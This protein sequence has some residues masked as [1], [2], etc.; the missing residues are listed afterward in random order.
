MKTTHFQRL[1][2][3][4]LVVCMVWS[5]APAFTLP[6]KAATTDP[7]IVIAGSDFQGTTSTNLGAD[8]VSAILTQITGA[9]YTSADGFL[10]AGDYDYYSM[11]NATTV[12]NNKATLKGLID[13][14]Y[15][16]MEDANQ[17]YIQGNHDPDSTVD[18]TNLTVTGAHDH[19]KGAYG[20]YV[21][22]QDVLRWH[23]Y[24]T[25][26]EA[27]TGAA[28]LRGYLNEKLATGFSKP[29]FIVGH[30]PLHYTMRTA[31]AGDGR[32]AH[33]FFDAMND[34]AAAGLNIIYLFGHHH[35][36]SWLDSQGGSAVYYGKGDTIYIPQGNRTDY[37]EET[38]NFT[39]MNAGFVGYYS[40]PNTT[41]GVEADLT[42]S[43]FE[44]TGD[45][46]KIYRYSADGLHDVKSRG[47]ANTAHTEFWSPLTNVISSPV[48]VTLNDI[49]ASTDGIT[50]VSD[51][52]TG[53]TATAIVGNTPYGYTA[54][55]T[56]NIKVTGYTKGNPATVTI[57]V[58]ATFDASRPAIVIDHDIG[59]VHTCPIVDGKVTFTTYH[60]SDYTVAQ[61]GGN[62]VSNSVTLPKA[63]KQINSASELK[64][65]VPYIISDYQM[66]W[67]LTN[68]A[69]ITTKNSYPGLLLDG[70]PSVDT[71]H[72]WYLTE[73]GY[74]VYGSATSTDYLLLGTGEKPNRTLTV[75]A[76]TE[77]NAGLAATIVDY[78][79]ANL[80]IKN[81]EGTGFMNRYGGGSTDNVAT[82][83][84]GTD[85][86]SGNSYWHVYE[87]VKPVAQ[88]SAVAS[89]AALST[90]QTAYVIPTVTVD[91]V[92]AEDVTLTYTSSDPSVATV[93]DDGLI[94][95]I[96]A[97]NVWIKVTLTAVNGET[98]A[99]PISVDVPIAVYSVDRD[100][101]YLYTYG[102]TEKSGI[103][104]SD[105]STGGPYIIENKSP[106]AYLTGNG[107]VTSAAGATG[108]E[109]VFTPDYD[110]VWYYVDGYLRYGK[111]T[112]PYLAVVDGKVAL[113]DDETQA[114][115][116]VY[117]HDPDNTTYENCFIIQNTNVSGRNA[118]NQFGGLTN[119]A[120]GLYVVHGTSTWKFY[121]VYDAKQIRF[122]L[123]NYPS[124]LKVGDEVELSPAVTAGT[125]KSNT[126]EITWGSSDTSVA[127]VSADGVITA[128]KN[129][130]TTITGTITAVGGVPMREDISLSF[131]TRVGE[132][133]SD[134]SI[135]ASGYTGMNMTRI[136]NLTAG[137][138]SGPYVIGNPGLV[139]MPYL[140]GNG[141]IDS[142]K[143]VGLE[144]STTQNYAHVW[145]Y[146]GTY[147]RYN[148]PDGPY[149]SYENGQVVLSDSNATAFD[150]IHLLT[151]SS[152][153]II[154]STHVSGS[155]NCLNQLGGKGYN[156][157]GL[158][159]EGS[160]S[161]WY[162][163]E[164]GGN[165]PAT[166]TVN[167]GRSSIYL[168]ETLNLLPTVT[169][170][171]AE[172]SDYTITWASS[173]TSVAT[174]SSDGVVTPVSYGRVY[175]TATLTKVD[176]LGANISVE[177]PVSVM[178]HT[179][180]N[181]VSSVKTVMGP[182][183]WQVTSLTQNTP[184]LLVNDGTGDVLTGKMYVKSNYATGLGMDIFAN[185][186]LT[187]LWYYDGT[188]MIY[189]DPNT[190]DRYLIAD[191]SQ[192]VTLGSDL[193]AA[194]NDI[195]AVSDYA[196]RFQMRQTLNAKYVNQL[197]GQNFKAA[198]LYATA[199]TR[200]AG[201]RWRIYQVTTESKV[202]LRVTP[203]TTNLLITD[204]SAKLTPTLIA[205]GRIRSNYS[206]SWQSSNLDVVTVNNYGVVRVIG[207]GTATVYCK[208]ETVDGAG[209]DAEIVTPVTIN[210]SD[211]KT[212][213]LDY[214]AGKV[215]LNSND[216]T[217]VTAAS[218][219]MEAPMLTVVY[220]DGSTALVPLIFSYLR[221]E[222]GGPIPTGDTATYENVIV[223]YEG[224]EVCT[225]FVLDVVKSVLPDY[226]DYPEEGAVF[227]DKKATGINFQSSAIAQVELMVN[228]IP[229]KKGSDV[230][231]MLDTSSSMTETVG[232]DTRLNVLCRS[233]NNLIN[234]FQKDAADGSPMDIRVAVADFNGFY[235]QDEY[236]PYYIDAADT[237]SN[238]SIRGDAGSAVYSNPVYTGSGDLTAGAFVKASDLGMN[239]F[240]TSNYGSGHSS[241]KLITHR[242]TNYDYAF[243]AVYQ[244]TDA[245]TYA[246]G[247]AGE[248]RDLFIIFMSDG[249][250]FQFNYF[251]SQSN[252]S[253]WNNYLLGT[254]EES[255]FA[256]GSHKEYYND[257]GQ[258]WMAE[259][260]K[261][262]TNNTYKIIRKN[263]H[264][265][266]NGDNILYI[267]GFGATMY[268]IG[269]CLEED[270]QI[271][272]ATMNQ[273]IRNIA[274]SSEYAYFAKTADELE[275]AFSQIS[276]DIMYAASNAYMTDTLGAE[277]D[278][279]MGH[280]QYTQNN[281]TVTFTDS[282]I[283]VTS[284][285]IYTQ[286]DFEKGLCTRNQIGVRK[287]NNVGETFA[288]VI[289]T[290][291]FNADGT[292]AYSS[293]ITETDADGNVTH[294]NIYIDGI[295][296]ADRFWY[297]NTSATK[298]ITLD[299]ASTFDLA[300]ETFYWEVGVI[301]TTE[302]ALS[303]HVYLTKT[304]QWDDNA[305]REAGS[306]PTNQ[307]AA[308]YYTNYLG[309]QCYQV[310]P[311]PYMPWNQAQVGYS[312]YLVDKD[313]N[314][315]T[316]QATGQTGYFQV[317]AKLGDINYMDF[318]ANSVG[319]SIAANTL[320][321]PE[322]YRLFDTAAQYDVVLNSDGTGQFA[323]TTDG[324]HTYSDGSP[325]LTTV[326]T[327]L[328]ATPYT[329]G[330]ENGS[331]IPTT[332]YM[333]GNTVVWFALVSTV[334]AKD[335]TVVIDFG[336]PVDIHPITNDVMM[337]TDATGEENKTV[338]GGI[339]TQ[340]SGNVEFDKSLISGFVSTVGQSIP[341]P[342]GVAEIRD[343]ST[344]RYTLQS[345]N[346]KTESVF[347][348]ASYYTGAHGV[349]GYYYGTI[350]VI[351]ATTIYYEDNVT[352]SDG[353][354]LINYTV[355]DVYTENGEV[356]E[357]INTNRFWTNYNET[358]K[359]PGYAALNG[360]I[361]QDEDRVALGNVY[362]YDS[363]YDNFVR[364]SM[365]HQKYVTVNAGT[366][367]RANF[368]FTGTG[369]DVISAC[370]RNSATIVVS[371]TNSNN[372]TKHYMVDTYYGYD[373]VDGEWVV[374]G[375]SKGGILQVPV[376]KVDC[377][378]YDE[379]DV[380]IYV[381]YNAMFDHSNSGSDAFY[382]DAIR[383]YQP[384]NNGKNNPVIENAYKADGEYSASFKELRN[385]IIGSKA[386]EDA[387]EQVTGAVFID[388]ISSVGSASIADYVNCGPN[389]EVY[390]APGQAIA[391]G[392]NVPASGSSVDPQQKVYLGMKSAGGYEVDVKV[393]STSKVAFEDT[394]ATATDMYY[395]ITAVNGQVVIV[396]NTSTKEGALLSLTNIKT[397]YKPLTQG[398]TVSGEE[399]EIFMTGSY[400]AMVLAELNGTGEVT[401]PTIT[402]KDASLS[403]ESEI[404]Y[405]AYF[406][407]DN[408]D[409]LD[410]VE[411]G[412]LT[413]DSEVT[414]G[415]I[416]NCDA[417]N[418]GRTDVGDR[419]GVTSPGV[420]AKKLGNVLY[421]KIYLK[422]ADGTYVYSKLY[423]YD[424]V[425]YAKSILSGSDEQM[426]SLVVAMLNYGAEAQKLF[427][428]NTENLVNSFLTE[429]QQGYVQA[430]SETMITPVGS[431]DSSKT[432][433]FVKNAEAFS[434]CKV[435]VTFGGAFAINYAYQPAYTIDGNM[436]MYYWSDA[437]YADADVLTADNATGMFEMTA[438]ESGLYIA[439]C[440]GIAAKDVDS[441]I[442][443][444]GTYESDGVTY[445]TGVF[446]YSLGTYCRN[447][448]ANETNGMQALAQATA[449]YTYYAK[450]Y[451]VRQ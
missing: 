19:T 119:N 222:D 30:I 282:K 316:S 269:F 126:Y 99:Y 109:L 185:G 448:A 251:G 76:L 420:P 271:K 403:F 90:A 18:G 411:M 201:S 325:V 33:Y 124:A 410:I 160:T 387:D 169:L 103:E 73:E 341:V 194:V 64:A 310:A 295:I 55:R 115:N 39:Y 337:G 253:Y 62:V 385:M 92:A 327:G 393:Y 395:D 232:S 435:G 134:N 212:V 367:A 357:R 317:A 322:G 398:A 146:D 191:S 141:P 81:A 32:Y 145:Y 87:V 205:D 361:I 54:Y 188:N 173:D 425:R 396:K 75:G 218:D 421:F 133:A 190:T 433:A 419:Y 256:Y 374:A 236:S 36:N 350:T 446:A 442:Y 123:S 171:G 342:Y 100:S 27:Q 383:I 324:N 360:L 16:D 423:N 228:G 17:I 260:L 363:H 220:Q 366:S 60:F 346:M 312:F 210:V 48:T 153:Y 137:T 130:T 372:E 45:N 2:A 157:A 245:I 178:K 331:G 429:E 318:H 414:D 163:Y 1:L 149:L 202:E 290:V 151:N 270:N 332:D 206:V 381:G 22:N 114:F 24:G 155:D 262:G 58:D 20:V 371:V 400:A 343:D 388:G 105:L 301:S 82:S 94:T 164:V 72:L 412:M 439:S 428:Y 273:V 208:L 184:Y 265:D 255:M 353:N 175:M 445:T 196:G 121:Q 31:T 192:R 267:N 235:S 70:T 156:A 351:P 168:D 254:M 34:A 320:T 86:G 207:P 406:T 95:G 308:L 391:F 443:A 335:D 107:P 223:T 231:I 125:S 243:D 249:C 311:I 12:I 441:T 299:D 161:R 386:F 216:R 195:T 135:T 333:T 247:I 214:H 281:Q 303:Y 349:H 111:K 430:Y 136:T 143:A 85:G 167:P 113:S 356:K 110:E 104:Q 297:N 50:V 66:E 257:K 181:G 336:L 219:D 304:Q 397:A 25:D 93:R 65:G 224:I 362:G 348:Y 289:E 313:G 211:I 4:V 283:E 26:A 5:M 213:T 389:N 291:T 71:T 47:V 98:L 424:A 142:A 261:G 37:K 172:T 432:A 373:Y 319:V 200:D 344:V 238:S 117:L 88:L 334:E 246:N 407:I 296:Y 450:A 120:A 197:G 330:D 158:W 451:L 74:L 300:P 198:G 139:P 8:T 116:N 358:S 108:L 436:T 298:R 159:S 131:T 244:L 106:A 307:R 221:K 129:G 182:Q 280:H 434:D 174:V 285:E 404:C 229:S 51:G 417:C 277:Y 390:L 240:W 437:D 338:I 242:G 274:T 382:L 170:D 266:D 368:T 43:V 426:K 226:P 91:D 162:F 101:N 394:I 329:G 306:Y 392:L 259:A 152:G 42:M 53:V 365:A 183:F 11:S 276:S 287:T 376:I 422:L 294:P 40:T 148:A 408:P 323:I 377:G 268:S 237:V 6:A 263:D 315:I 204:T 293:L 345:M 399:S 305:S 347:H 14:A 96:T 138:P 375:S 84:I 154:E 447:M 354:T 314:P 3:L 227:L 272:E 112:G 250:P 13:T 102:Y 180:T 364:F 321:L 379:Y 369:F 309:T 44:I 215:S 248:D 78:N 79:G 57:P 61:T 284:Y 15:P 23:E 378:A 56:Y 186:D 225:D 409:G 440:T 118:L 35:S 328:N 258:H 402:A 128:L 405:N 230:I 326:V 264:R 179:V 52:V 380:E 233:L 122:V 89:L 449:V 77:S 150:D 241:K 187:D 28:D 252:T 59:R 29:I 68:T 127:T 203:E 370:S 38:L 41:S 63:L 339:H 438:D 132:T 416:D 275:N 286:A 10:F 415:T 9:G 359:D 144:L 165:L 67:V 147:L 209:V 427:S 279:Q 413:F 80:N 401:L 418:P 176:G 46:V 431:V 7:V 292:E 234:G 355:Y 302:L 21:I 352:G 199:G 384:A 444:V 83:Y 278:L 140:T 193:N 69:A 217:R 166:L 288:T 177:V 239:P 189:G 340:N 49:V 97:G